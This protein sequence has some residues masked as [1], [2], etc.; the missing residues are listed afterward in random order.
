MGLQARLLVLVTLAML[1]MLSMLG[2]FGFILVR[3]R[4]DEI[5]RQNLRLAQASA[6]Y[7]QYTLEENLKSLNE[8][9]L[10]AD[11][12]EVDI[13]QFQKAAHELYLRSIFSGGIFLINE[14]GELLLSEPPRSELPKNL[15]HYSH[16]RQALDTGKPV[17]SSYYTMEP[18]GEPMVSVA[19]P[20]MSGGRIAGLIVGNIDLAS[21]SLQKAIQPVR[22]GQTGYIDIIDK[23]GFVLA[24]TD[25]GRTLHQSDHRG[26]L[27]NLIQQQKTTQGTC[28]SCH[29]DDQPE[30][31][32]TEIMAFFPLS[33]FPVSAP[34]GV[35]VRQSEREALASVRSL[36]QRFFFIGLSLLGIG[37]LLTWGMAQSIVKPIRVLTQAARRIASGNLSD[38]IPPLGRDEIGTL[39]QSFDA[40]REELRKSL[41]KIQKWNEELEK[42]VQERTQELEESQAKRGEL[43][44]KLISAH[45]EERK[46]IARELHDETSQ[47]LAA[48][49][50]ALDTAAMSP[51]SEA[52]MEAKLSSMKTMAVKLLD[53]VRQMIFDLRPTVLDDLGL[54]SAI[55]WY[56]KERLSPLG[57][58]VRVEMSGTERRLPSQIEIALFRVVQEAVTNI[59]KHAEAENVVLSVDFTDYGIII[60]VEDDGKGF[61]AQAL[62]RTTD[63]GTGLGLLGMK[64]RV[65]LLEGNLSIDSEPGSGTRVKIE[66]PL[67]AGG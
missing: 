41:D 29:S 67:P 13:A 40:M 5:L 52:E 6:G 56:A 65:A 61:D 49:T 25:T 66:V 57:V 9:G 59:A 37:I 22:P 1:L 43:L 19:V 45:E 55:R 53:G 51:H 3:E 26:V 60:E 47:S 50:V 58:K 46:R 42:M 48:L 4:V 2:I 20:R 31:R 44:H 18:R 23:E 27:G 63:K 39:A 34:W 30:P 28:H 15:L 62:D 32:E 35:V 16:I 7:I 21:Q 38:S 14:R 11:P 33:R 8:I 17:I 64:E 12:E 36:Q 24:S 54:L 10:T